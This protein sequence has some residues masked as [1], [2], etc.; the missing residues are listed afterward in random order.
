MSSRGV[1]EFLCKFMLPS[2]ST[3][4]S[5]LFN[6]G[7]RFPVGMHH[8]NLLLETLIFVSS[9]SAQS[10][11][12]DEF[13]ISLRAL[14]CGSSQSQDDGAT[15]NQRIFAHMRFLDSLLVLPGPILQH[16][17]KQIYKKQ[18]VC[19]VTKL[20]AVV[21]SNVP[22]TSQ[23]LSSV[24]K[25][26][27]CLT[28]MDREVLKRVAASAADHSRGTTNTPL[29]NTTAVANATTR[30]TENHVSVV[31][32]VADDM[33]HNA[34]E[35]NHPVASSL[36]P[37]V[38]GSSSSTAMRVAG[39]HT[40]LTPQ[41]QHLTEEGD[42]WALAEGISE[43]EDTTVEDSNAILILDETG[44]MENDGGGHG[45]GSVG[46]DDTDGGHD[47]ED[48]RRIGDESFAADSYHSNVD[49]EE[50]EDD[51]G[52]ELEDDER[53]EGD[54]DGDENEAED[55]EEDVAPLE[56]EVYEEADDEVNRFTA[57]LVNELASNTSPMHAYP[58]RASSTNLMNSIVNDVLNVVDPQR[59]PFL[60]GIP[61][62]APRPPRRHGFDRNFV[63]QFATVGGGGGA[64]QPDDFI[65]QWGSTAVRNPLLDLHHSAARLEIDT[66]SSPSQPFIIDQLAPNAVLHPLHPYL[67]H[68]NFAAPAVV[69]DGI[70]HTQHYR[71]YAYAPVNPPHR[72]TALRDVPGAMQPTILT[73][74]PYAADSAAR[75]T[76]RGTPM[77][78]R[79]SQPFMQPPPPSAGPVTSLIFDPTVGAVGARLSRRRPLMSQ[80]VIQASATSS[81]GTTAPRPQPTL[82]RPHDS[83]T[84]AVI[85]ERDA[86]AVVWEML[87]SMTAYRTNAITE[88]ITSVANTATININN[89]SAD[90]LGPSNTFTTLNNF[91]RMI[92][93]TRILYGQEVMDMLLIARHEVGCEVVRRRNEAFVGRLQS[94]EEAHHQLERE[95][96]EQAEMDAEAEAE[97]EEPA[98]VESSSDSEEGREEEVADAEAAELLFGEASAAAVGD[99]GITEEAAST[100]ID[101]EFTTYNLCHV[102]RIAVG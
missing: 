45:A 12:L 27:E 102:K 99:V 81:S 60:L 95:I 41:Q 33:M 64:N 68:P 91:R 74:L 10:I 73:I 21:Q 83:Q 13:K 101:G 82:N 47:D 66:P 70:A 43:M 87:S 71:N 15:K 16:I 76:T 4:P 55:A 39:N 94:Y 23:A 7:L 53:D 92:D 29:I 42:T 85:S 8:T 3:F 34:T 80:G 56:N 75:V 22:N 30:T 57:T 90:T 67:Q 52:E 40:A 51:D 78:V 93:L 62:Y 86:D 38:V 69:P 61:A 49:D 58:S 89:S 14:I 35:L 77:M 11:L 84:P 97:A 18:I 1:A 100:D 59:D 36:A 9:P 20:I 50:D 44:G 63:L 19:D 25:A 88:I 26:L 31:T 28:W 5:Y 17:I 98:M 37:S 96:V 46:D 79:T 32:T 72:V 2:G 48:V 65:P 6:E 54:N 24:V